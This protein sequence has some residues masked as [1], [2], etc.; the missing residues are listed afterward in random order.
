MK[1]DSVGWEDGVG[2]GVR[3][4]GGEVGAR[5]VGDGVGGAG[6][7]GA[8]CTAVGLAASVSAAAAC[9]KTIGKAEAPRAAAAGWVSASGAAGGG[10]GGVRRCSSNIACSRAYRLRIAWSVR[11]GSRGAIRD[12]FWPSSATDCMIVVSSARVQATR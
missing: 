5:G 4:G 2:V 10:G 6:A 8:A 12:H 9:G 7:G 11:P 1:E 3:V